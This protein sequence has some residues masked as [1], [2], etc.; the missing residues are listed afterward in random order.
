MHCQIEQ[1]EIDSV[2]SQDFFK[3]YCDS[4]FSKKTL[5][6]SKELM[7]EDNPLFEQVRGK[8]VLAIAGGPTTNAC[9]WD[10]TKYDFV[11]TCNH[12]FLHPRLKDIGVDFAHLS[13]ECDFTRPEFSTYI[14]RFNT[15]FC[16]ENFVWD[17]SKDRVNDFEQRYPGR[18]MQ[19]RLRYDSKLGVGARLL[20][21]L[22][23]LEAHTVD[24]V[25]VDGYSKE[26]TIGCDSMHSFEAGKK[27]TTT[28]PY[29]LYYEQFKTLALI[30]KGG[31]TRFN[32][33]GHGHP[34]NMLTEF[35]LI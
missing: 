22:L 14:N 12:F 6:I 8:K 2:H 19:L 26:Y 5:V 10:H 31:S 34:Y 27:N 4:Y 23:L 20:V 7:Y 28:Y 18:S 35:N 16:F 15:L 33:L 21:L 3:Q 32:N 25:G 30:L 13:Y 17:H 11:F 24:F 9:E 1:K 29:S